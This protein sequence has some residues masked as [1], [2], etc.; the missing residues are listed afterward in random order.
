MTR[1]LQISIPNEKVIVVNFSL[2]VAFTVQTFQSNL[3]LLLENNDFIFIGECSKG[4]FNRLKRLGVNVKNHLE[5]RSLALE[6][7]VTYF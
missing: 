1:H 3:K 7:D 6:H 4:Y 5:L 2:I